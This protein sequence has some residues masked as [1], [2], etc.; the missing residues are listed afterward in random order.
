MRIVIL[1]GS[2]M[3]GSMM[4]D[5]LSRDHSLSVLATVRSETVSSHFQALAPKVEWRLLNADQATV[6]AL[7]DMFAGSDWV[8]NCIGI[9]KPYIREDRTSETD[10]AIR[11]NALFP[12]RL[13]EAA[14]TVG[15]QVLQIAT[16]CVFSGAKGK[17]VEQDPH[18][19]LDVYGKTKS[20][21][22]VRSEGM[23]H[24]RVSIIGPE[25]LRHAFLLD[26]FLTQS[27]GNSVKGFTNHDWN[28][29][30]TLHFARI[31]RGIVREGLNCGYLQHVVPSGLV[32]KAELLQC[33][34]HSFQ[35]QDVQI[36]PVAAPTKVDRTLETSNSGFNLQLWEAAGYQQ[37]PTVAEMVSELATFDAQF[38]EQ[39]FAR[40]RN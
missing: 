39:K 2:G 24:L 33:F 22:E 35:R 6:P 18:D 13:A 32:S 9:T 27:T 12:H 16:D 34:A 4:V 30:T 38:H 8:I 26:W 37:P 25:P 31:C 29:V 20:L 15:A 1:G 19:A 3:L 36:V 40:A 14:G 21:G 23:H 7:I 5:C 11:I 17:Y 10:R 28:G